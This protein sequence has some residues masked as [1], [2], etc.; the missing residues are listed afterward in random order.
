MENGNRLIE[1]RQL[2]FTYHSCSFFNVS[3]PSSPLPVYLANPF[4]WDSWK[5]CLRAHRRRPYF[6]ILNVTIHAPRAAGCANKTVENACRSWAPWRCVHDEALYKS[7]FTFTLFKNDS[8]YQL[9]QEKNLRCKGSFSYNQM[10][11][12]FCW[13]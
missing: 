12:D 6:A 13:L 1:A 8:I 4:S 7:T 3:L 5:I 9:L 2:F 11:R 10:E